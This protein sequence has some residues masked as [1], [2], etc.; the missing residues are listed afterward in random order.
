MAELE[1]DLDPTSLAGT[2]LLEIMQGGSTQPGASTT[3]EGPSTT[4]G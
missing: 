2:L 1:D 3:S 4:E